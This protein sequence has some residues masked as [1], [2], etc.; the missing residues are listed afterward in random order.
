MYVTF[1]KMSRYKHSERKSF[2][3]FLLKY[4][5][6][7]PSVSSILDSYSFP[8]IISFAVVSFFLAFELVDLFKK[9]TQHLEMLMLILTLSSVLLWVC[10]CDTTTFYSILVLGTNQ[11]R[12][13]CYKNNDNV[14]TRNG[15]RWSPFLIVKLS[16]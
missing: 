4:K 16:I 6:P 10:E 8:L 3:Y 9:E 14:N 13:L 7:S 11:Q 2:Y 12:K 15:H 5:T 1:L